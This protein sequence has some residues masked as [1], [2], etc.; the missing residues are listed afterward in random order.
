LLGL[1]SHLHAAAEPDRQFSRSLVLIG[2]IGILA[3][4]LPSLAA[5]LPLRLQ[6]SYDRFMVSMMIGGSLL[7]LGLLQLLLRRPRA[8]SAA[9]ALLVALGIGQQFFNANI[10]RRDWQK[11]GEIYWQ[12]AWRMPGLEAG[13]VLLTHQMPVDYETDLSFT[14]PINWMYA[15]DFA[16][17]DLPFALL[18]T[19]KRLGGPTLPALEPDVAINFPYRTVVF[20]GN[21]SRAVVIYMPANGCLRVLD[22]T[23]GDTET[24]ARESPYLVEAIALSDPSRILADPAVPARPV[25]FPETRQTWCFFYTRAELAR[26]MNAWDDIVALEKEAASKGHVPEDPIEWLPFIEARARTGDWQTAAELA[27][28]ALAA[29]LRM[30]GGLCQVWKRVAVPPDAR[31]ADRSIAASLQ[32]EFACPR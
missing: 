3:G 19:E 29:D 5:G 4:R 17:T 9:L 28:Q 11:Q 10:F 18:Y 1:L 13:T 23:L 15:P 25:F 6:S 16:A 30:R 7:A 22:P 20:S 14:A 21:T 12:M 24:Y 31:Q 2:L 32:S 27:R 8:Q 26:Q